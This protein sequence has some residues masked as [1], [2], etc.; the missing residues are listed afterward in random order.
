LQALRSALPQQW[1]LDPEL[2]DGSEE[3][4][5]RR[6]IEEAPDAYVAKNVLR[7]RTGSGIYIY[8]YIYI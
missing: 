4:E 2:G 3:R 7:P 1:S 6:R 8:I 5:A